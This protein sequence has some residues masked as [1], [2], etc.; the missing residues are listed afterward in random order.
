MAAL[1][2]RYRDGDSGALRPL[3][4]ERVPREQRELC[5]GTRAFATGEGESTR[6]SFGT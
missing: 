5:A 4:T 3:L 2:R 6:S 1:L